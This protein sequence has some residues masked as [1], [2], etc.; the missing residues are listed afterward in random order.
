MENCWEWIMNNSKL[1]IIEYNITE[2]SESQYDGTMSSNRIM[3]YCVMSYIKKG[4]A[5][6]RINGKNYITNAGSLLL[7]PPYLKH[8]HYIPKGAGTTIFLWWHFNFRIGNIVDVMRLIRFPVTIKVNNVSIFESTFQQYINLFVQKPTIANIIMRQAKALEIMAYLFDNMTALTNQEQQEQVLKRIPDSFF[9]ILKTIIEH[10]ERNICLKD[11]AE[12][13]YMNGTYIS[14][15]FRKHFGISP[16]KLKHELIMQKARILLRSS[17]KSVSDIAMEL[18]FRD[19]ASFTRF[20]SQ[21]EGF[22]PTA[23]RSLDSFIK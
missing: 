2:Y 15:Q 1:D 17:N 10:P 13:Y 11:L 22:A 21:R 7:V 14:N 6:A 4:C 16:V 18:G 19:L 20:F 8:D 3:P 5:E 12:Q 23:Y 9:D